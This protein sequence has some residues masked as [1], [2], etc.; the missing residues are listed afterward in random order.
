MYVAVKLEITDY[1]KL[2]T[3]SSNAIH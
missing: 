1:H 2:T 3:I